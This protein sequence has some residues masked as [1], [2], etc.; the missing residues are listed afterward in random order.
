MKYISDIMGRGMTFVMLNC[1]K[2]TFLLSKKDAEPLSCVE[3]VKLKMHLATC[4]YCRKFAKQSE[5]ITTQLTSL[6]NIDPNHLAVKLTDNQK[7]KIQNIIQDN[8]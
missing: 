7:V 4:I 2:A 8:K 5:L 6:K 3:K 1:D